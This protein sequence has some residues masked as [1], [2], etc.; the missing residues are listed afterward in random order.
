L[1]KIFTLATLIVKNNQLI[2]CGTLLPVR[3]LAEPVYHRSWWPVFQ[4]RQLSGIGYL[5][6]QFGAYISP[7]WPSWNWAH[8]VGLC[9]G[10]LVSAYSITCS[11]L[12]FVARM[13]RRGGGYGERSSSLVEILSLATVVSVVLLITAAESTG[14]NCEHVLSDSACVNTWYRCYWNHHRSLVPVT[15][16]SNWR[17]SSV[18]KCEYK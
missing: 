17:I 11:Q 18:Q 10:V 12:S 3:P 13:R 9:S 8:Y 14:K 6:A 15:R 16:E 1:C 5:G 4:H 7:G 2:F